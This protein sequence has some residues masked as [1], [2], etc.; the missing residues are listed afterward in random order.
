MDLPDTHWLN[1][2]KKKIII[3]NSP[4]INR[5]F[6]QL[7]VQYLFPIVWNNWTIQIQTNSIQ[8]QLHNIIYLKKLFNYLLNK[9]KLK[10][11][12]L[13][14]AQYSFVSLY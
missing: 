8:I 10:L 1:L 7:N 9:N 3:I 13:Q 5:V 11:F 12:S 2:K 6:R 4:I 14:I